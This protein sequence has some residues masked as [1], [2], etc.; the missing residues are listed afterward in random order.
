MQSNK[1]GVSRRTFI[2]YGA[3][4]AALAATGL[5]TPALAQGRK[6][7]IFAN[8]PEAGVRAGL[9]DIVKGFTAASGTKVEL[10]FT[11]HEAYKTAIRNFLVTDAPDVCF[12]FSGNRMK[13]FVKHGLFTDLTAFVDK[14]GYRD[15]L[16]GVIS[17][18]T[19]QGK[20]WG[21]PLNGTL[22]G[23]F[24]LSNVFKEKGLTPPT[25]WDETF[26]FNDKVKGMGLVPMTI[27][28]KELWPAAGMFDQ[29]SLR[30]IGLE[31]H[32]ALM[33]GKIKYTDPVLKPIFD[34]WEELIKAGFFLKDATSYGWQDAAALLGQHKAAMMNLGAFVN[35]ALPAADK[36]Y[37]TYAPFP[38]IADIP[39]Y[40]D[41]S[42]DSIH[43]PSKAKNPDGG[44]E[45]LAYFYEPK[46]LM[47][48]IG[49]AGAVPPRND[50]PKGNNP[51][52]NQA[53]DSLRSVKGTAQYYDRDTDPA[54]AQAGLKGFQE[55]MAFPDRRE[56]I[57]KRLEVTRQRVFGNI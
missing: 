34:H 20:V 18:V 31:K 10:S 38:K 37:L 27:G 41:F 13:A 48:F 57:L 5:G 46:N 21:L 1:A 22:W 6:I 7:K 16:G 28:T 50:I 45:F 42:T 53:M 56:A 9:K 49:P 39:R 24:Y 30:T 12:W 26:A 25:T 36:D 52:I 14:E 11:D 8:Q 29:F 2:K 44:K 19:Y 51:L 4:T 47:K 33:D 43:V 3:G 17:A 40:E 35:S 54:M 32:M 23:N 55:F 15:V